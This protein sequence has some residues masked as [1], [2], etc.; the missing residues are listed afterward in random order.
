MPNL[1][2]TSKSEAG[3]RILATA[4]NLFAKSG[5]NGISTREIAA[6]AEVNEIT[7]YRHYPHK[8]DL[9]L[10]VLKASLEQVHLRGDLLA[11]ITEASDG[12]AALAKTFELVSSA[13]LEKPEIL[14]LLR[15]S[16]LEL[17]AE[18]D[19]L[20]RKYFHAFVD[21]V[22]GY[23]DPWVRNGQLGGAD[24]RQIVLTLMAIVLSYS[25]LRE[26]FS[27]EEAGLDKMF[28]TCTSFYCAQLAPETL[29]ASAVQR[30]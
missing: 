3:E 27:T 23:L 29:A 2:R 21:I 25:S 19:P 24:S 28:D 26:L 7:V 6:A 30:R 17:S 8:H 9:Y 11:E 14:R 13:L 20:A 22:A 16:A 5:F 4:T 12:R 10:S 15:Y 18:F 1:R